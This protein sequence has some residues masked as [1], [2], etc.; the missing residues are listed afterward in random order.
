MAGRL[1]ECLAKR[2]EWMSGEGERGQGSEGDEVQRTVGAQGDVEDM[3]AQF[4]RGR[5]V[6]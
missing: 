6:A 3:R 2:E 4:V 1:A 5:M